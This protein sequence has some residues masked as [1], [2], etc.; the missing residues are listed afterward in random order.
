LRKTLLRTILGITALALFGAASAYA[1]K[2]EIGETLVS[3]TIDVAPREL[4]AK[5]GAPVE[6]S[7]VTRIGTNDGSAPGVLSEL[8]FM[9][10]KHGAVDAKGLPV[11]TVAK[12]EGTTPQAAR[13]RCA[14]AIVGE[15][16]GRAQVR[17]PG[18]ATAEISSPLTLFNAPPVKGMP[19]LLIHAYETVPVAQTVL[20]P[21]AI[22]RINHGR[23]GFQV[24]IQVPEIAGG[25]GAAT[26]AKATIGKT[27]K[28]GGKTVGYLSAY[29]AGG[30]LQVN[31]R[32]T[33]ADGSFFPGTLTSPC[34]VGG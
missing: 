2:V 29:C 1:L 19:S 15:G 28:R 31:G 21:V 24:K 22:E 26:L 16:S 23:Y 8:R 17:M 12:L 33:M 25:F 13:K 6:V 7:S 20:V 4:P 9:F 3:A 5:G 34:H 30:R 10:D 14:G 27:W 18:K 11:C 32:I